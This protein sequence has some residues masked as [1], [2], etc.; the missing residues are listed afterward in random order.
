P[1]GSDRFAELARGALIEHL[2]DCLRDGVAP[3]ASGEHA[4][5]VLEVMLAAE[6][7]AAHGSVVEVSGRF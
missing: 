5:H 3:I 7:S 1:I 6:R 2:A 4:R